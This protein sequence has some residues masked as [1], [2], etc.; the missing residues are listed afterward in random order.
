MLTYYVCLLCALDIHVES[1]AQPGMQGN[2]Q[3][4]VWLVHL[5][6]TVWLVHLKV[7]S[8]HK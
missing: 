6:V 7:N 5:K 1:P 3:Y 4:P 2:K 8:R